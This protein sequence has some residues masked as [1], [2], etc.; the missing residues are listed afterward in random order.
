MSAL[1]YPAAKGCDRALNTWCDAHCPHAQAHGPLYARLD[2]A[3][4]SP[5]RLAWRCYAASTLD[6]FAQRYVTGTTYCT[7]DPPLRKVLN[8]CLASGKAGSTASA[9]PVSVVVDA[10]GR[11]RMG[12]S[13]TSESD[14]RGAAEARAASP[15]RSPSR[16]PTLL[17]PGPRL[18]DANADVRVGIVVARCH[19][20]MRWLREV[21]RGLRAGAGALELRLELHVYEKCGNRSE[22][23]WT[24]LGWQ[25]ERRT[26][27]ANRGEEVRGTRRTAL[28]AHRRGTARNG[29]KRRN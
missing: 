3:V 23:A 18:Y 27:L 4:G 28:S 22:D 11:S 7:R 8:A 29:T 17:E 21:Q 19:E 24:R 9:E 13:A 15:A 1:P 20:E 25:H 10:Q 12:T 16:V 26:Y 6:G 5:G 14:H 2:R